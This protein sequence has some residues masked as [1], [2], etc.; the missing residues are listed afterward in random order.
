MFSPLSDSRGLYEKIDAMSMMVQPFSAMAL[1]TAQLMDERFNQPFAPELYYGNMSWLRN[2][3]RYSAALWY[4]A[5]RFSQAYKKP[6]WNINQTEVNGKSCGVATK[7]V[8]DRPFCHVVHFE[9]T[10]SHKQPP[11]LLV[12]PMSGHYATLLR[13]TVRGLLPHFDVYITDWKNARDVSLADGGFDLDTY[14]DYLMDFTQT[15]PAGLHIVAVCQAVIPA[16]MAACL[17][18]STKDA[19]LPLSCTMIGGPVDV[20]QNPTQPNSL[21][22]SKPESWFRQHL[23]AMVPRR[24]AGAMRLVY[25]GFMQLT[26]FMS[27]NLSR[28]GQSIKD[29]IKSFVDGDFDKA[30]KTSEFYQEYFSVMD[31]TAE[32]YLQTITN[33]FRENRLAQGTMLSRGRKIDPSAITKINLLAIEG[34]NDDICGIG[35]TE[36]VLTLCTN[37]D[38]SKKKYLLQPNVGHYGLFS[39]GK[40]REYIVPVIAEI[41]KKGGE[42]RAEDK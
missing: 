32:F 13:D 14:V 24:Y 19:V 12:A 38:S 34:E 28:H 1:E 8:I 33:I 30:Q 42:R 29:A 7:I 15:L 3:C 41:A 37:L 36:S 31:M 22:M 20:E 21:A 2:S 26:S 17:L 5:A 40:F 23:V 27:M 39:G 4:L 9:K 11:L 16:F 25:P 6:D 18:S 35:Q 10:V